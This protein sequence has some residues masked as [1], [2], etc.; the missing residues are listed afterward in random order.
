MATRV[1]EKLR[2]VLAALPRKHDL[3]ALP[4]K[5]DLVAL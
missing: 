2:A 4:T 1:H 3:A 5:L